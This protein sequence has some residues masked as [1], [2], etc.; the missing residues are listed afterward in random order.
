MCPCHQNDPQ[1]V[2]ALFAAAAVLL[3]VSLLRQYWSMMTTPLRIG[4]VLLLALVVVALLGLMITRDGHGNADMDCMMAASQ[5]ADKDVLTEQAADVDSRT[6]TS[7]GESETSVSSENNQS[8]ETNTT[9]KVETESKVI[10]YYFHLTVRCPTCL[11]IET[12]SQQAISECFPS[13]LADGSLEYQAV[14]IEEAE[15]KHFEKDFDLKVQSLVLVKVKNGKF[16]D[17]K[18]L[19]KVWDL[20]ED[21]GAFANYV[22]SEVI[23]FM[24]GDASEIPER[25]AGHER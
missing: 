20:Y 19:T 10:A 12:F 11:A 3:G 6:T 18:N 16:T 1:F 15:N 8:I 9:G 7:G 13:E 5:P 14:N 2:Y 22:R 24:Y 17:W 25:K 21:Y 4:G 23:K